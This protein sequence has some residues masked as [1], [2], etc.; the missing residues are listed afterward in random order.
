MKVRLKHNEF[1]D[2]VNEL[3]DTADRYGGTDQLRDQLAH[4]LARR[5]RPV[6]EIVEMRPVLERIDARLACDVL[7]ASSTVEVLKLARDEI[8]VLAEEVME[9]RA[10]LQH[11]A[12][13]VKAAKAEVAALRAELAGLRS[14]MEFRTSL[15]GRTEAERDELRAKTE[16]MEKQESVA[17]VIKEGDSRYWMSERLWT[18]PDGKY[19]LYALPG[20]QNAPSVPTESIG[21]ML[22]QAMEAAV[23]NGANSVSMPDELVEVAAWL[24][25]VQPNPANGQ[26][27]AVRDVIAERRRQIEAEGRTTQHDDAN[28]AGVMSVAAA[29]Y[30]IGASNALVLAVGDTS[31][32]PAPEVFPWEDA[33]WKPTT[34]RRD[35]V[36]AA[37][38]ILAEIERLDR[39]AA[40][41]TEGE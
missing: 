5:V 37:A 35:L 17:T 11:E 38:L 10:A 26:T 32:C 30:A 2:L 25:G 23:A 41:K 33:W 4:T 36:K 31:T 15:I 12:D 21:K 8:M 14:S 22:A 9:L 34:P 40:Q 6:P 24:S 19:P 18:F 27:R 7:S 16:R 29:C 1:R 39:A 3:R 13:R 20:A 28:P